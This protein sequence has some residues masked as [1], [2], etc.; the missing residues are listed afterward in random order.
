M[1]RSL[2]AA[3]SAL[4]VLAAVP[5]SAQPPFPETI[6]LTSEATATT[7]FQGEGVVARGS[8][9]Y[10]GSLATGTIVTADL[11]TGDVTTLV[12]SAGGPAVGLAL[13][14]DLLFVAGGPTG[15]LRVY[16]ATSGDEI[17]VVQLSDPGAGFI[18]D[19]IVTGDAA[20]ATDSFNATLYRVPL[21]GREV[22]EP[23]PLTLTGD[24][25]LAPGFNANGI[26]AVGGGDATRL[27]LAQSADPTDG[28]GSALYLV[29]PGENEAEAIRIAI[30]GDV[31]NAD[32]IVLRGRTLYVVENQ[33][34]RVAIVRLSG[35]LTSG[36]VTGYLTDDDLATP[37][38]A[39][40]ALGALYAVNARFADLGMGADPTTLDFEIVRVEL[41]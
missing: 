39:T 13:A 15:E 25:E 23:E 5:A 18:N 19:V 24:F 20:Y 11:V 6:P 33:Q 31:T 26:E 29:E 8:T 34:D 21:T 4:L 28:T 37:T 1:R 36:T 41:R 14:G 32:G 7:G 22:G 10:A 12:A 17:A 2:I 30:D 3:L 35:D 16:D 27:I 9:A 40:L 38:T